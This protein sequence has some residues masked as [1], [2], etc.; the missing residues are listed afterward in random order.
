MK[1]KTAQ[2]SRQTL[3]IYEEAK[4]SLHSL[5]KQ[6]VQV[7]VAFL[8]V[9][10]LT[11]GNPPDFTIILCFISGVGFVAWSEKKHITQQRE[12][13]EKVISKEKLQLQIKH[14]LEANIG[15]LAELLKTSGLNPEEDLIGANLF[16][17]KGVGV[18]LRGFNLSHANLIAADLR[19]ADLSR[20]NLRNAN[21]QQANL[22]RA[23]LVN[24][25]LSHAL[26][27]AADLRHAD[28]RNVILTHA[29]LVNANLNY[30]DLTGA[31]LS[32]A[33]LNTASVKNTLFGD[34]VGITDEMQFDLE[35]RG[36]VFPEDELVT[37]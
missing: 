35:R 13:A 33:N 31:N 30:A 21:L 8:I 37:L 22:N 24:T 7:G 4:A 16:N 18:N 15:N 3:S 25:D 34:N 9:L 27:T 28:M 11:G 5:I 32:D 19:R 29:D 20:A 26:L 12:A 23:Y 6:T 17:I 10:L 36:A 1:T 2:T 14:L